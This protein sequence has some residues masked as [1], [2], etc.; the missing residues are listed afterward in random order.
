MEE[1]ERRFIFLP[2]VWAISKSHGVWLLGGLME[3]TPHLLGGLDLRMEKWWRRHGAWG[4]SLEGGRRRGNK[5]KEREKGY[6]N[7]DGVHVCW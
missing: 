2:W 7:E 4:F 1:I 6:E 5:R 3:R